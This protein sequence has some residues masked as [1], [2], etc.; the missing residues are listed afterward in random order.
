MNFNWSQEEMP[1]V[2]L[3]KIMLS[4]QDGLRLSQLYE[5]DQNDRFDQ[6]RYNSFIHLKALFVENTTFEHSFALLEHIT[7][8][9]SDHR[10]KKYQQQYIVRTQDLHGN[11]S[12][13]QKYWN[14]VIGLTL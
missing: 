1:T 14:L 11:Y 10:S 8:Y 6:E 9:L 5:V 12:T 13:T 4:F 3:L 7:L 2:D